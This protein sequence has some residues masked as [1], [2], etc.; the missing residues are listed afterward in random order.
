MLDDARIWLAIILIT[1]CTA[2]RASAQTHHPH[3]AP[4]DSTQSPAKADSMPDMENMPGMEHH[5]DMSAMEDGHDMAAMGHEH[6]AMKG[7][8]GPYSISR[9]ASG[10]AW[11]PDRADHL[12]IHETRGSWTLMLHGMADVVYDDQ[13]GPRGDEKLFSSN[14][15]MG[16]ARRSLGPGTLGFRAMVSMEP[17]TIGKEGYPLLLQTGETANGRTPLIDRQHPHDLFMELAASYSVASGN[18]SFF[19]Y[20]GLPGEPALGPPAFMHRFSG[21]SIPEAPITHH[22]LDSS[23]ITFGVLTSG[24][25]WG[26]AK[27]EA[28]A[29]RGREPD[30]DRYDIESPKLDSHSFRLSL[31]PAP[32]WAFQVSHGRLKSPEQLEPAVNV[33][34]TTASAMIAGKWPD[35]RWGAMVAWGRNR[36]RPGRILNAV[37]G[38]GAVEIRQ[39]HTLFARAERVEK[40]ELFPEGDPREGDAFDVGE[41]SGGYRFD[42]LRTRHVTAGLGFLGTVSFV[43]RKI[44]DAYGDNPTSGMVFTHI[45]L[46]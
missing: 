22:W 20:G 4:A 45:T 41:L 3:G 10:T 46:R 13:G 19:L 18:H 35:G 11:Q 36:N 29:F 39:R 38:E 43:P 32:A 12:G 40:D 8:Y 6:S 17:L 44:R 9:E 37:T 5:H 1:A 21:L 34:R 30:Q 24:V 7:L 16:M 23:H 42:F 27:L 14:M 33:D 26:G 25:T 2:Q 28:S 31:N 15:L